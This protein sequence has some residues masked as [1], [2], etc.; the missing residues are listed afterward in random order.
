MMK[1][2]ISKLIFALL[3][4][5]TFQIMVPAAASITPLIVY[6]ANN[7]SDTVSAID[8]A[9]NTVVATIPVG[10][11]P[12]FL[13]IS[14]DGREVYVTN[15]GSREISVINTATNTVEGQSI[16]TFTQPWGVTIDPTGQKL[17]YVTSGFASAHAIFL[18][19]DVGDYRNVQLVPYGLA[20]TPDNEW[21]FLI[22]RG[23]PWPGETGSVLRIARDLFTFSGTE[24]VETM[25][26]NYPA[27]VAITPDSTRAY[28]TNQGGQTGP[29]NVSVIDV[30]TGM[31]VGSP[32][33]VGTNPTGIAI[34][35]NGARA[36]VANAG[37]NNVSVI[38][39]ATNTTLG[40]PI[41]VGIEP[42]GVAITTD[43]TRVY[44]TNVVSGTVSVI[45]TASNTVVGDPIPV[46]DGPFG[47]AIT[48]GLR[49]ELRYLFAVTPSQ[50]QAFEAAAARWGQVITRGFP[51]QSFRPGDYVSS[52]PL[53]R[54]LVD[55]LII[56]VEVS[57][58]DGVSNILAQAYSNGF[59]TGDA[60]GLPAIGHI[61]LDIADLPSIE[62]EGI[63]NDVVLHEMGHVLGI[64]RYL[65]EN[66]GLFVP[67]VSSPFSFP[68]FTGA[69]AVTAWQNNVPC[70]I[71]DLPFG[72]CES[73]PLE[74]EG[75]D[76]TGE[77]H[78]WERI[79]TNELMTRW[80]DPKPPLSKITIA[81]LA[82]LGYSVD[83]RQ[84]DLW[85]NPASDQGALA[86]EA[87]VQAEEQPRGIELRE[88]PY[89]G[90]FLELDEQGMSHPIPV[91]G[92]SPLQ[93]KEE[94]RDLLRAAFPTGDK[95]TDRRLKRVLHSLDKS[96]NPELWET[97]RI[98]TRRGQKVFI[99][100]KKAV[101]QLM[102]IL[103]EPGPRAVDAKSALK[104][105][106]HADAALAQGAI[107]QAVE[108]DQVLD[109]AYEVMITAQDEVESNDFDAAV[110]SYKKV[111]KYATKK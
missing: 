18:K 19:Y 105:L 107:N 27:R 63:L 83:T 26:G 96:L 3:T 72:L 2:I 100:E 36:Y 16:G 29:G 12:L 24:I 37:S 86:Q 4:C 88:V 47:I 1:S 44:V 8:T 56:Y 64:D 35:P 101:K 15:G 108:A 53:T 62:T 30:A 59:R 68:K 57:A 33:Q 10:S 69:N 39:T 42:F 13:A 32:I 28:V 75:D 90:P 66:K 97:D 45:D 87:P 7:G 76:P 17:F 82:D 99:E 71:E 65:W 40:S 46:G 58:I 89:E 41:P 9:T 22:N 34:T 70:L 31:V 109:K 52:L 104:Q 84:S 49:I 106:M 51:S 94:V 48:P 78:W 11:A 74:Y 5:F 54:E 23:A 67:T 6:V 73:I 21:V 20:V 81:A 111:W 92:T 38:D 102:K 98:L 103:N 61:K 43:G 95:T 85:P 25:V 93:S 55:D 110:E 80:L 14:P 77:S 60:G 91:G 79:F 50:K